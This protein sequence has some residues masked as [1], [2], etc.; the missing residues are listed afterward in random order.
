MLFAQ[1]VL[2]NGAVRMFFPFVRDGFAADAKGEKSQRFGGF[3][4]LARQQGAAVGA[5]PGNAEQAGF[6]IE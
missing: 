5:D 1:L 6:V 4:R 2:R 3:R